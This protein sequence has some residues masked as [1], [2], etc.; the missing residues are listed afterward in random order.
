MGN[1]SSQHQRLS[2][3]N[4]Q[5][6]EQTTRSKEGK[7]AYDDEKTR[8]GRRY[9]YVTSRDRAKTQKKKR[10][11]KITVDDAEEENQRSAQQPRYQVA[12]RK[13]SSVDSD[14]DA[15]VGPEEERPSAAA[16]CFADLPVEA[17]GGS[18]AREGGGLEGGCGRGLERDG[19]L[20]AGD[21]AGRR[22]RVEGSGR[23]GRDC[24]RFSDFK[25]GCCDGFDNGGL[26]DFFELSNISSG[27]GDGLRKIPCVY[28][29]FDSINQFVEDGDVEAASVE[30]AIHRHSIIVKGLVE[31]REAPKAPAVDFGAQRVEGE[32]LAADVDGKFDRVLRVSLLDLRGSDG[33]VDAVED[34]LSRFL[35]DGREAGE[36]ARDEG[37]GSEASALV[38][39]DKELD[40]Y[41]CVSNEETR[42][43]RRHLG[44]SR[45]ELR[46]L[47]SRE[48]VGE[49]VRA[50]AA[51]PKAVQIPCH[52]RVVPRE[53]RVVLL[54][55]DINALRVHG[56]VRSDLVVAASQGLDDGS[57][58]AEADQ[59][60]TRANVQHGVDD[61]V[62]GRERRANG[63][64]RNRGVDGIPVL[65]RD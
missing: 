31:G 37:D 24:G 47:N 7:C 46:D 35:I 44:R 43:R 23:R 21:L 54:P 6:S 1:D 14:A 61:P 17:V 32:G 52:S 20:K 63:G 12:M 36:E 4:S 18:G 15:A 29:I 38:E 51:V 5:K 13:F 48:S 50:I 8:G 58:R 56:A 30:N 45:Q 3:P 59:V 49:R 57:V 41:A 27:L 64:V 33:W 62:P 39:R 9:G 10:T 65:V 55:D 11:W 60:F 22:G 26:G 19:G 2:P 16:A 53:A 25:D 34:G 28:S 40:S 42:N